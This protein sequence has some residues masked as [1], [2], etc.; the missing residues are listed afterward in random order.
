LH[1][2]VDELRPKLKEVLYD[3]AVEIRATKAALYLLDG[4]TKKY[5]LVSEFGFRSGVRQT[6]GEND[7]MVDRCARGRSPF[8][9]NNPAMEP[10]LSQLLFEASTERLMG[11][12]LFSRGLLI[13]FIDMRDKA[14]KQAFDQ[15]D[16][17]KAQ[18]I[19][20]RILALFAT[21][22]VWNQRSITLSD[23]P[24]AAAPAPS[25]AAA[26]RVSSAAPPSRDSEAAKIVAAA[27]AA[28]AH[29]AA[30]LPTAVIGEN[31]MS[32]IAD[33]L[34]ALL[35]LPGAIAAVFSATGQ[36]GGVQEVASRGT[37][38]QDALSAMQ[39]K[40]QT[41]LAKRGESVGALKTTLHNPLGL[42]MQPITAMQLEKVLTAAV[43][44]ADF[45]GLYLTVAFTGNPD[46]NTHDLLAALLNQLQTTIESSTLRAQ[47]QN[48]RMQAAE[49]LLEPSYTSYPELRRHAAS[50]VELTEEFARF[51]SLP[52]S[53]IATI[54][55]AAMVHD[56]GMRFLDYE[57]LYRKKDLSHDELALL[58]EHVV[59]GAAL[60]EPLL[61]PE[62]ARA[63]LC[64]HERVDG[65]GY[66]NELRGE[67]IPLESR[68]LQ[69]CDV[70]IA[71]TDPG[72]YQTP[73]AG[74]AAL[75]AIRRGAGAQFDSELAIRFEQMMRGRVQSTR[76]ANR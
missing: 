21:K 11:V 71:I 42:S 26:A 58:R 35:L 14:Q 2:E 33:S 36:T 48:V 3:C 68:V 64:H 67:N 49:R 38:T 25:A 29:L 72:T 9:V 56:S 17:G 24:R 12:P 45:R 31:E 1:P 34:R 46:R 7:P 52:E 16:I 57:K 59:V 53:D 55:L 27:R 60:A 75:A 44:A 40:L 10:R 50:V 8:Y 74:D 47:L 18:T 54:K 51:L 23:T 20:D 61:G 69:I 32:A 76:L 39:L 28:T 43:T 6:A 30:P 13:G 73:E 63:V 62:V 70:Y 19:A 41:W 37:M 15:F 4:N 65:A 66:P 22:N 5:E